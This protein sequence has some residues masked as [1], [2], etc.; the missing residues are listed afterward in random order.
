[1][2]RALAAFGAD[3]RLHILQMIEQDDLVAVRYAVTGG[4]PPTPDAAMIGF[5]RF[6]DGH[7]AEDWGI[8]T[9]KAWSR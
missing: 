7:I 2:M 8:A 5:Y 6:V 1:M 3:V 4:A 9:R